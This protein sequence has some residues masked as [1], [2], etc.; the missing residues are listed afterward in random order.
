MEHKIN[1]VQVQVGDLKPADYNPRKWDDKTTAQLKE[2]ILN[3]GLIDPIIANGAANRKNVVIGGHFRLHVAKLLGFKEV[4]VVYLDIPEVDKEMELNVRLNKNSGEWDFDLLA[5]F[6]LKTLETVGFSSKDIDKMF[7]LDEPDDNEFDADAELEKIIVPKSKLGDVYKLGNH[8]LMCGDATKIEDVEKL[9]GGVQ[10]DLII[11]DPPYNVAYT[12][13]TKDK[14]KIENDAMTDEQFYEFL[15]SAFKNLY[16]SAKQGAP[17]YVFHAD[18]EG[19]NFR[20]AF[21][22]SGF[23]L[24]QCCIWL[25]NTMVLGRRDYQW[26]HEP[27]LY[28]WKD[29]AAHPWFADR[30]ETTIWEFKKP[31]RSA[32]HP[33]MKPIDLISY[34]IRNSSERNAIVLDIFGG[35]GSTLIASDQTGRICYTMEY[36]PKYVD[37]IVNRWQKLTGGTAELIEKGQ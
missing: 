34:P 1:I 30:S 11:T 32:E 23:L 36:D 8:R 12:G 13:K 18:S 26:K 21:R 16:S 29:G 22:E 5:S 17:I 15:F 25:K 2:S 9:M 37:V 35:S 33:T 7:G 10:A 20:K 27:I 6:N 4:P 28:G 14:L 24:K 3:F 31:S 19:Y